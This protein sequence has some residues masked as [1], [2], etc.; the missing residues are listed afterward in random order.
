MIR[1]AYICNQILQIYRNLDGLSFPLDPRK[2]F[3]L[4]DNCKLMTY[5]TFSEINRCSLQEVFLLCE[6]QSGCT[7]YDVSNDRYLV[8]FNS[9][10]ANN[11]VLGRIRWTLAHELGHVVLKHL[12]YIAEPH[13]AEHNFNNLSNPELEAEADYFAAAFLC[14]IPLYEMLS[15]RSARDIEY[16]F[17]LSREASECRWNDYL[18]WKQNHRKTAWENDLKRIYISFHS[19]TSMN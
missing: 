14:P 3:Q 19:H 15:I 2:P 13:I 16:T 8:L 9:S 10:T 17:G 18:K 1:Y 4:M 12:P 6:S 7:H 5:K 11:N